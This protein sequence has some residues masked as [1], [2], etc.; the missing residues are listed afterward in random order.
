MKTSIPANI[1][2]GAL[3]DLA[4]FGEA[5]VQKLIVHTAENQTVTHVRTL[6][7]E[8]LQLRLDYASSRVVAL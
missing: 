1:Y 2:P 4:Y 6:S 8:S 5:M 7:G 3:L